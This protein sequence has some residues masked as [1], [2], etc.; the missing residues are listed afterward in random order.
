MPSLCGKT[1]PRETENLRTAA[2]AGNGEVKNDWLK[3]R[4][5]SCEKIYERLYSKIKIELAV[6][7]IYKTAETF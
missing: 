3:E 5:Q 2:I 4:L 6:C 7:Y 1:T